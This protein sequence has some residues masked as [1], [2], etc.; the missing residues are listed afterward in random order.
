MFI[1]PVKYLTLCFFVSCGAFSVNEGTINKLAKNKLIRFWSDHKGSSVKIYCLGQ[2]EYEKDYR[3]NSRPFDDDA[4]AHYSGAHKKDKGGR[5]KDF[6]NNKIYIMPFGH[7]YKIGSLPKLNNGK[8]EMMF[9]GKIYTL[10]EDLHCP[11]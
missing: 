2:F 10:I 8:T 1:K 6:K 9:D 11:L 4:I 3:V 5:I 7:S